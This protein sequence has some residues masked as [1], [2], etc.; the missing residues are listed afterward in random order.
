ME[1]QCYTPATS[2]GA[3]TAVDPN[4][5]SNVSCYV[6]IN[7]RGEAKK[8][9]ASDLYSGRLALFRP[10]GLAGTEFPFSTK[11]CYSKRLGPWCLDELLMRDSGGWGSNYSCILPPHNLDGQ[12]R[13]GME[14]VLEPCTNTK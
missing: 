11:S 3:S 14:Y 13:R 9:F 10:S 6:F 8:K 5:S 4:N 12:I 7:H 2:V 1:I